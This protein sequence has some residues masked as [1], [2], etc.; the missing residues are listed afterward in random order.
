[1]ELHERYALVVREK[2]RNITEFANEM[3][4]KQTYAGKILNGSFGIGMKPIMWLLEHHPDIDARW[5]I[6][7]EGYIYGSEESVVNYTIRKI[8]ELEKYICVMNTQEIEFFIEC[9]KSFDR[10]FPKHVM[11]RLAKEYDTKYN[12]RDMLIKEAIRKNLIIVNAMN[13]EKNSKDEDDEKLRE[14]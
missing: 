9:M 7:G 5:L 8:V 2:Y 6:T 4:V 10:R 3:G 12:N 11:E 14:D 13:N 1:M